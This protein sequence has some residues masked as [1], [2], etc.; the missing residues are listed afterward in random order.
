MGEDDVSREDGTAI[1]QHTIVA[2]VAL[3][4][5]DLCSMKFND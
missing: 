3:S 5:A 4:D 1:D 2:C